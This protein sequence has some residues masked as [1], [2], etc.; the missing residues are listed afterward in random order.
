MQ[1][2]GKFCE[3]YKLWPNLK[4]IKNSLDMVIIIME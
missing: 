1:K 3:L 2:N 4:Q